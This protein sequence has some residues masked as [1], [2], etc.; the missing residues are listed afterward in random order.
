MQIITFYIAALFDH[1]SNMNHNVDY[2]AS[3]RIK[4]TLIRQQRLDN[5]GEKCYE[6]THTLRLEAGIHHLL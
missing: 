5:T 2:C 3:N 6:F 4:L 1:I